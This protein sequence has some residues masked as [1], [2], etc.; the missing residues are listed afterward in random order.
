MIRRNYAKSIKEFKTRIWLKI[1]A[2]TTI[3]YYL[4][5]TANAVILKAQKVL[6]LLVKS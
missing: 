2:L 5:C 1:T 4:K 3:Q 6:I